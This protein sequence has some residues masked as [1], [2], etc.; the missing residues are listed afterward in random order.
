MK[1]KLVYV[2]T[3]AEEGT[4]IEQALISA[5][6]AR[7][8]NPDAHIVLIVD[9][10][11]NE[12]LVG[13]RAEV[14]EYVSEKVVVELPEDMQMRERSRYIKTSVRQLVD[15]D[16]LFI[17][18]DTIVCRA[19]DN[20][21]EL[22]C[23]IGAVPDSHLHVNEY[24]ICLVLQMKSRLAK[25]GV[26][27]EDIDSYFSSGV[28]YVKDLPIV[29]QLYKKWYDYWFSG[30]DNG[31]IGDQP[32]LLKADID[33]G[34]VIKEISGEWNTVMYAYPQWIP[35]AYILH[36]SAHENMNYMFDDRFL[37]QIRV[38]GIS[39]Y[40]DMIIHHEWTYIANIWQN[41]ICSFRNMIKGFSLVNEH[42]PA[43]LPTY[44]IKAKRKD[45]ITKLVRKNHYR[46]ASLAVYYFDVWY[47]CKRGVKNII[48]R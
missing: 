15:G 5:Y 33:M 16:F 3:C 48:K 13:K 45:I 35:N 20:V 31:F 18:T 8:H 17:D 6:S 26:K 39:D 27:L 25:I 37:H 30:L 44:L 22:G 2:L 10:K 46:I 47:S 36:F 7:Y 24:P 23:D 32:Y 43:S 21:E 40:K 41:P 42:C 28:L 19:L 34:H 4:Y 11:T 9:D 38:K 29:H 1:T 14:L 12:L